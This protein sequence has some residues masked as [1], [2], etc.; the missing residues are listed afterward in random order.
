[1]I[2]TTSSSPQRP[3]RGSSKSAV[4]APAQMASRLG[5]R[6]PDSELGVLWPAV[7]ELKSSFVAHCFVFRSNAAA[8][9]LRAVGSI[10]LWLRQAGGTKGAKAQ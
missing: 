3:R 5:A 4:A 10:P 1:M 9:V 8:L 6:Y 2:D 7:F